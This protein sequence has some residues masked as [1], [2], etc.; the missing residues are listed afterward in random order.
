ME[1]GAKEAF[2][3]NFMTKYMKG[4]LKPK[5][6][7]KTAQGSLIADNT[8]SRVPTEPLVFS[9]EAKDVFDAGRELWKY[10]HSQPNAN[11]NAS[12]YDIKKCFQGVNDKG[13]MNNKSE[14][15]DY[16]ALISNLRDKLKI[17]AAKI[18]PKV[19]EHGFLLK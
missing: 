18:E 15:G 14:D 16:N 19:Y 2:E 12:L 3:S 8:E 13:K 6:S 17:L 7:I 1:V 4:K 5:T 9:D 11:P 10:Y